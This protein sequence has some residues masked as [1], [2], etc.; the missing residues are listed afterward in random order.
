LDR[1]RLRD[2]AASGFA[3][4]PP[5]AVR[6]TGLVMVE[7]VKDACR[8]MAGLRTWAPTVAA[9]PSWKSVDDVDAAACDF[10]GYLVYASDGRTASRVKMGDLTVRPA[11]RRPDAWGRLRDEQ[12]FQLALVS[13]LVPP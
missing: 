1:V 3:G 11:S 12:M 8:H 4:A 6:L 7:P 9:V 2:Y 5:L 13:G 10:Y